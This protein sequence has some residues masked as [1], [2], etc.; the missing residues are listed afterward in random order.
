M[1]RVVLSLGLAA[2][3]GL[4]PGAPRQ[5][6]FERDFEV[7]DDGQIIAGG[8]VYTSWAALADSGYFHRVHTRC[9]TRRVLG[10]H[11]DSRAASDCTSSNNTILPG[12]EPGVAKYRI[13]VVVHVIQDTAGNGYLSEAMVQ[14]QIDVLNEDYGALPGTNGE[15]GYDAQI[16][17]Y[18]VTEDP[19][20]NPTTGVTYSTNDTWFA[21]SGDYYDSLAWDPMHYMNIYTNEA[22]GALGY[23]PFTPE[24]YP[25][26]VGTTEDRVVILYSAFGR[27]GPF[28][29]YDQ[30]RT[31]THEVGHFLGLLHPFENGCADPAF[32][33]TNGD[34]ICDTN[35]QEYDIYDCPSSSNTCGTPDPLSN[36]MNYTDDLCMTGFTPDQINR[37]RCT[38]LNYRSGLYE[39][40]ST[41]G[42][43]AAD[44][45]QSG[46]LNIDDINVFAQA[47]VAGD[48]LADMDANGTLNIDDINLF[49]QA[50]VAGCP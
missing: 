15:L 13:P 45:D 4:C 17:F 23:V 43:N 11:D 42:C 36:Y 24:D 34:L 9:G 10:V 32:C 31:A 19:S 27:N 2:A 28:A 8:E 47:F 41:G 50:F 25:A 44:V 48:M 18:L 37:I 6:V 26:G 14:S 20:G 21:D 49:A 29:P 39:V 40:V 3:A 1:N 16:E 22:G 33:T 46:V 38:L 30:G 35:P 12:Y 5:G 7:I